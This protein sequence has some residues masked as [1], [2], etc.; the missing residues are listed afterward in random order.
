MA[1]VV[2]QKAGEREGIVLIRAKKCPT[3]YY[4]YLLLSTGWRERRSREHQH[5]LDCITEVTDSTILAG[6]VCCCIL[7]CSMEWDTL[8]K[9]IIWLETGGRE[10]KK[11]R[12]SKILILSNFIPD[13]SLSYRT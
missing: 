3:R 13:V 10:W 5:P 6:K 4:H 2:K 8:T 11:L 1:S 7:I 12:T 9:R